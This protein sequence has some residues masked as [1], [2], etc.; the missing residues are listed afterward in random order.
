MT[1]SRAYHGLHLDIAD[2]GTDRVCYVLLPEGL[3]EEGLAWMESA[4]SKYGVSVVI[5]SG[6]DW[7]DSL[8][9]WSADGIFRKEKPFGGDAELFQ[10]G[11]GEDYLPYI[12]GL[13]H[14][15]K[16][17]R[18]LVGI[19]LSG[20]FAVW[21]MYRSDLFTGV[22]SISGSLWYDRFADWVSGRCPSPTVQQVFLSLGD[23]EK[24]TKDRRMA[25]VEDETRRIY[26]CIGGENLR[27][28]FLLE[29]DTTHF[30]PVIPRLEKALEWLFG[31]K[32]K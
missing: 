10:K 26:E 13:L 20:L 7:N 24:N 27:K 9:P 28:T 3:K 6:M 14:V 2:A 1:E 19:S 17:R 8:T 15:S 29:E 4:S 31:E 16:P 23:R 11:L 21:A 22:A 30:S 32:E 5:I 18:Y 12:E 25:T